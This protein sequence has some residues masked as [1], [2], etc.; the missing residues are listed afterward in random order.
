MQS[1]NQTWNPIYEYNSYTHTYTNMISP[2]EGGDYFGYERDADNN[3]S[4]DIN[5]LVST[6]YQWEWFMH[7]D[8]ADIIWGLFDFCGKRSERIASTI[9]RE[10]YWTD[11]MTNFRIVAPG[12]GKYIPATIQ[13]TRTGLNNPFV[14]DYTIEYVK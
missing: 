6:H 7:L 8:Y 12:S 3:V 11:Q 1:G 9:D 13:M 10:P 5:G 4:V 2:Q 14:A